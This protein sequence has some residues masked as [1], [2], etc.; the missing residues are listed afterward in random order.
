MK[1]VEQRGDSDCLIACLASILEIDYEDVSQEIADEDRQNDATVRFLQERGYLSWTLTLHGD[2][3]PM[4]Q[5]GNARPEY[6]IRP[7]GYWIAGVGSPRIKDGTHAVV[8]RGETVAWDPHPLREMGHLG[9]QSA[10]I[11]MLGDRHAAEIV[12]PR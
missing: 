2:A 7:T 11:I 10:T 4:L 5:F 8:M 3:Q 12:G 6:H 1:T 9:F